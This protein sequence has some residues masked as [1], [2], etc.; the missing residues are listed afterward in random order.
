LKLAPNTKIA[1]KKKY[2]DSTLKKDHFKFTNADWTSVY[3]DLNAKPGRIE[4]D[5]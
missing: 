1:T 3:N 5:I 2:N 4:T